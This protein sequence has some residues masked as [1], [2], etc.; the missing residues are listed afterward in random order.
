MRL[1]KQK[2][3]IS[4]IVLIITILVMIILA[5]A[6]IISL[7][8][9]GIISKANEA[10]LKTNLKSMQD[11]AS[12]YLADNY[13]S[14][15]MSKEYKITEFG[16]TDKEFAE[17]VD[18]SIVKAGKVYIK[19]TAPEDI[20]KVA[21]EL[22]MLLEVATSSNGN[23]TLAKDATA[24]KIYGNSVSDSTS[25]GDIFNSL[26]K[27]NRA[28]SS[29]T[30]LQKWKDVNKIILTAKIPNNSKEQNIL[31]CTF[32][33]PYIGINP[34]EWQF[35]N[36]L[37]NASAT[38]LPNDFVEDEVNTVEFTFSST[39]DSYI[40]NVWDV[41][42]SKE[43][44][45]Y[46]ISFYDASNNLIGDYYP[47]SLYTMY[48]TV[49]KTTISSS[50]EEGY[51]DFNEQYKITFTATGK[52]IFNLN[53]RVERNFG[54]AM[55]TNK[56]DFIKNSMYSKV[57]AN[58]YVQSY[59]DIS[60]SIVDNNKIKVINNSGN[61]AYG[62]GFNFSVIPNTKYCLLTKYD[63][64][65]AQ[66]RVGFYDKDGNY[67][68]YIVVGNDNFTVPNNCEWI[69]IVF[70]PK[71]QGEEATFENIYL[72]QSDSRDDYEQYNGKTYSIYLKEPLRKLGNVS[73]YIDFT[74]GEVVRYINVKDKTAQNEDNFEVLNT[75]LIE[76]VTVPTIDFKNVRHIFV[77]TMV[78]PSNIEVTY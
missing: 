18:I 48:D 53:D 39:S 46:R 63:S 10:V 43:V 62:V 57:S 1:K 34:N 9:N 54:D 2:K 28:T 72:S 76:K 66:P 24:L 75:P 20:K 40:S 51:T 3:G 11:M 44:T 12:M 41:T 33:G 23:I 7:S 47:T 45:Y 15:D 21:K 5:A 27:T 8:N 37:T 13:N 19:L 50:E 55:N 78:N 35:V 17:Y 38:I 68:D 31:F 36:G 71:V 77:N 29:F 26:T 25:V 14:I 74:T 69:N 64:S 32:N 65:K 42:W 73:D 56:R 49:S 30:F 70:I 61:L 67:I 52:N 59:L 6:T 60:Y 22:N 4:L 16:I 58:N